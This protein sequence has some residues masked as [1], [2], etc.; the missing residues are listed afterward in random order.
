MS[1]VYEDFIWEII[2]NILQ[3]ETHVDIA[4][5]KDKKIFDIDEKVVNNILNKN[6]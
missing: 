5:D 6:Y 1:T 4:I 3:K 2:K